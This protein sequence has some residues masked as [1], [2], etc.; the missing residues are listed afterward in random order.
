MVLKRG[1][2]VGDRYI[3]HTTEKEIQEIIVSG[4]AETAMNADQALQQ[5]S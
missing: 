3:K 5:E 2:K 1:E 4:T